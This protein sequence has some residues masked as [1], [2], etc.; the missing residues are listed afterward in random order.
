M[1]N[2]G[3]Y[4]F[5]QAPGNATALTVS[6]AQPEPAPLPMAPSFSL[7][8]PGTPFSNFSAQ[9]NAN[10]GSFFNQ[11]W[12]ACY[13]PTQS[14]WLV[15]VFGTDREPLQVYSKRQPGSG[16]AY[17]HPDGIIAFGSSYQGSARGG[18]P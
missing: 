17:K 15:P 3:N 7:G 4:L 6:D 12:F 2:N 16:K 18:N 9:F 11:S 8:D 13:D 1:A 5:V 10:Y 14:G